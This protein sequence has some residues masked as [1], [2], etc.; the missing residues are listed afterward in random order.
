MLIMSR[1]M[2][3][4]LLCCKCLSASAETMTIAVASNF[5]TA[6]EEIVPL[7]EAESGHEVQVSYGSSGRIYAQIKNGAP[8][9]VFLSADQEKPAA[10]EAEGQ[11]VAGSRYTYARGALVLWSKQTD[12]AL[13][14]A[15]VLREGSYN[16][17]ALANPRLAPYGAAALEVL[18]NL[19]LQ[20]ATRDKRVLGENITQ[21][22]QFVDTGNAELGFVA[23]SQLMASGA[24]ESGSSWI[25]PP[26]L[27]TPIRQDL[28]LL[29][30][31]EGKAAV[32]AFLEFLQS[33]QAKSVIVRLG[34]TV[35]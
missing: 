21:A 35:D 14:Q 20:E 25:I 28:V 24:L 3:V 22:Y 9:D 12:M 17:L 11:A 5:I 18:D 32:Q 26:T 19:G 23:L 29:K 34:Y 6:M 13:E 7:F 1:S 31:A 2:V 10:L 8:F 16:K 15:E 4:L 33:T 27:Y 30:R